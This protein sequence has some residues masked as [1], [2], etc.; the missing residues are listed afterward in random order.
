MHTRSSTLPKRLSA[1]VSQSRALAAG[2]LA[3]SISLGMMAGVAHAAYTSTYYSTANPLPSAWSAGSPISDYS[4]FGMSGCSTGTWTRFN[5]LRSGNHVLHTANSSTGC[6]F[7]LL[8]HTD[9]AV[10]A[11]CAAQP[12]G[13]YYANCQVRIP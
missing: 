12:G 11:S 2:L 3:A 5:S 9:T 13:T 7:L 8:G 4:G 1:R 6:P 10:Y